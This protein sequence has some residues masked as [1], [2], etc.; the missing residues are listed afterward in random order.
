MSFL[1]QAL[2]TPG[3]LNN[4]VPQ[5]LGK[6]AF[7]FVTL[8]AAAEEADNSAECSIRQ[9]GLKPDLRRCGTQILTS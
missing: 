8:L 1:A 5:T 2:L 4:L 6:T 7:D 3:S 9:N